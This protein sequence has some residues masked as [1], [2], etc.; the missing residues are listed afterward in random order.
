LTKNW[1]TGQ[2]KELPTLRNLGDF[3][4]TINYLGQDLSTGWR[5]SCFM[6]IL[7]TFFVALI[8]CKS[9]NNR[10]QGLGICKTLTGEERARFISVEEMIKA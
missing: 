6:T 3:K 4:Q 10:I 1:G 2:G 5:K 9:Y 7:A 8:I